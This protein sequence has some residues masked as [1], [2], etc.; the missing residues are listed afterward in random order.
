MYKD[1]QTWAVSN[2]NS[3]C[4]YIR[5]N[6]LAAGV[7]K[8]LNRIWNQ[9]N[10]S[11]SS[12]ICIIFFVCV[13]GTPLAQK[14]GP[15]HS[16]T[17]GDLIH[18]T[19][20]VNIRWHDYISND[21]VLRRTDLLVASSILSKRRL[22]LFRHVARLLDDVPANQILQTYSE[23]EMVS[24][25]HWLKACSRLTFPLHENTGD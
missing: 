19:H 8:C 2:S 15:L 4:K 20:D 6:G 5:L 1:S 3:S 25:H 22:G 7:M 10:L 16:L 23:V 24:C 17:W 13:V 11:T 14:P 9:K 21:A 12:K 18:F